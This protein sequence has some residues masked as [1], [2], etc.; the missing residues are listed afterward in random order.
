MDSNGHHVVYAIDAITEGYLIGMFP[1]VPVDSKKE[2]TYITQRS[3][4]LRFPTKEGHGR[5]I[6]IRCIF[7]DLVFGERHLHGSLRHLQVN[8]VDPNC[9]LEGW[10][11]DENNNGTCDYRVVLKAKRKIESN[12]LLSVKLDECMSTDAINSTPLSGMKRGRALGNDLV[13]I[14]FNVNIERFMISSL[15]SESSSK[16]LHVETND[17]PVV[18]S[19]AAGDS[20]SEDSEVSPALNPPPAVDDSVD[21]SV[22]A[23]D[24]D[25]EDSKVSPAL[26]PP[27]AVDDSM[28]PSVAAGD[29]GV[30][31]VLNPS[32]ADI[33]NSM[34]LVALTPPSKQPGIY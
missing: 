7:A 4:W 2:K 10:L 28:V 9:V 25:S 23:E 13:N 18:P 27:P 3:F 17:D 5:R 15:D 33:V 32:P 30:S 22:A 1:A 8:T 20:D 34:A 24:A 19:V 11:K 6:L 21:P 12:E 16:A 26:N 29:S 31:P 14:G